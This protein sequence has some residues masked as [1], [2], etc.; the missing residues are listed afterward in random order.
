[1]GLGVWSVRVCGCRRVGVWGH[2]RVGVWRVGVWR[3]G[4][5]VVGSWGR[6]V[7]G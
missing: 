2:V 1:M 6:G 4:V 3:V 7:A 5:Q